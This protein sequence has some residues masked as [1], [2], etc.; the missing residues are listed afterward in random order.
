[1]TGLEDCPLAGLRT[2][3]S[4]KPLSSNTNERQLALWRQARGGAEMK[5]INVNRIEHRYLHEECAG[6]PFLAP[7][8]PRAMPLTHQQ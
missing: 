7:D 4:R 1:M 5:P 2:A 6:T 8:L 3:L